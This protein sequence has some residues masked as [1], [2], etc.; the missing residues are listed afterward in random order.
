[1]NKK[2]SE[3]AINPL[4]VIALGVLVL[5]ILI[6]IFRD[7]IA[8]GSS[9]YIKIQDQAQADKCSLLLGRQCVATCTTQTISEA[10]ADCEQRATKA[11]EAPAERAKTCCKLA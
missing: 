1:M 2:G 10:N 9:S 3:I 5:I 4:I 6:V 11:T 7:Q 8:K